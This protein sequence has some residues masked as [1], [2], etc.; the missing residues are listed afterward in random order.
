MFLIYDVQVQPNM[1]EREDA[2]VHRAHVERVRLCTARQ[3]P[4]AIWSPR[5][6]KPHRSREHLGSASPL[7]APDAL[8]TIRGVSNTIY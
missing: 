6:C 1:P 4:S 2:P 5:Q 3:S 8:P 7:P